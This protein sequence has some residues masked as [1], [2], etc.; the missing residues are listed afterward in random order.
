MIVLRPAG[1]ARSSIWPVRNFTTL[2]AVVRSKNGRMQST[3]LS[4]SSPGHA[5]GERV[6]HHPAEQLR[7][8]RVVLR[9]PERHHH[10]GARAVP[11]GR[12]RVL[13]DEHAHVVGL[14]DA[15]RLDPVDLPACR[16]SA[17]VCSPRTWRTASAPSSGN[18]R[19]DLVERAAE[20]VGVRRVRRLED[21]QRPHDV[22][23][24]LRR[25]RTPASARSTSRSFFA[26]RRTSTVSK[27]PAS[28]GMSSTTV[29]LTRPD[30][31]TRNAVDGD[32]RQRAPRLV[33]VR[34]RHRLLEALDRRRDAP[35][36]R[37]RRVAVVAVDELAHDRR[38]VA[39][40][41]AC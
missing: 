28:A 32:R 23:R 39:V 20:L 40:R 3:E 13:G 5:A 30:S 18:S 34:V 14:L 12:D 10:L 21:Q 27:L 35:D 31:W 36:D 2:P 6:A 37:D 7:D 22:G 38:L 1:R 26:A 25:S 11:A 15:L 9:R 17:C 8:V 41:L 33:G 19:E 29:S 16:T 24:L 4:R